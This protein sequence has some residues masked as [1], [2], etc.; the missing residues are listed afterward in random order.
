MIR[1]ALFIGIFLIILPQIL[2]SEPKREVSLTK[3]TPQLE[4]LFSGI[5]PLNTDSTIL[6]RLNDNSNSPLTSQCENIQDVTHQTQGDRLVS[7]DLDTSCTLPI[8]HYRGLSYII[9]VNGHYPSLE[10]LSDISSETLR[11]TLKASAV[12][13]NDFRL[14]SSRLRQFF[15]DIETLL[16]L[17]NTNFNYPIPNAPLPSKASQLPN[18]PRPFRAKTT[19]GVHH[20]W[21]FYVKEN[22]PV[23]AI[24]DGVI[25]QVKRDFKWDEMNHLHDAHTEIGKQKN[26]DVYRGNTV[27]LKTLSGHVAIYAHL[28][29]IPDNIEIG[30]RVAR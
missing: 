15:T 6:L 27:Y 23:I 21:D 24:E 12:I 28:A 22:T 7:L 20:G 26:L 30:T 16:E 25:L 13:R 3:N 18:A 9:P 1:P 14:S 5:T 2:I 10:T 4:I 17:R 19:D 11:N 29:D 8:I